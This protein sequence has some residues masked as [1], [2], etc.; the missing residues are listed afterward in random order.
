MSTLIPCT[1]CSGELTVEDNDATFQTFHRLAFNLID[2][3]PLWEDPNQRGANVILPG[4]PGR[5]ENPRRPD[6]TD[7]GL[8]FSVAGDYDV[9]DNPV[10]TVDENAQLQTNLLYIRQNLL[11]PVAPLTARNA[12]LISPDGATTLTG[13]VQYGEK[14]LIRSFRGSG[15]WLGTL[16]LV[17]PAGTFA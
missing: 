1:T 6:E 2:I 7:Y 3:S 14:P 13:R 12:Q 15:L 11:N 17:V 9:D 8:R 10:D 5:A 16:H 4:V